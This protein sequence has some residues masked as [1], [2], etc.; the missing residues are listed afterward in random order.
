MSAHP[1]VYLLHCT[2]L[3]FFFCRKINFLIKC[4]STGL[5][6]S[7][8]QYPT[9]FSHCF[10]LSS[11]VCVCVCLQG[12]ARWTSRSL[13]QYWGQSCCHP[14]TE[15]DFWATPSTT[16]FGRWESVL[17]CLSWQQSIALINHISL[18][19]IHHFILFISSDFLFLHL[20][21]PALRTNLTSYSTAPVVA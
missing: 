20:W 9:L 12:T 6:T 17:R 16:S 8:S 4:I 14:T 5:P 10:S 2:F 18:P 11:V 1:S 21:L 7:L 15:K 19:I 3:C 13:W